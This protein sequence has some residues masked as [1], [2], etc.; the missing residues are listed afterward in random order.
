M[1][2]IGLTHFH[3][4]IIDYVAKGTNACRPALVAGDAAVNLQLPYVHPVRLDT[5]LLQRPLHFVQCRRRIAVRLRTAIKDDYSH[6][7]RLGLM[8]RFTPSTSSLSTIVQLL[9]G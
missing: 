8:F 5:L 1:D 3:R 4:N 9:P 2:F 7:Y 6:I